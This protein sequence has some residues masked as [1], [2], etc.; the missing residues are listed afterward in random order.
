LH[1][2]GK[3]FAAAIFTCI[4]LH[5][6]PFGLLEATAHTSV[7]FRIVN[8]NM[9]ILS[10]SLNGQGPYE[11]AFDTGT[12][13]SLVDSQLVASL[14]LL[15]VDRIA[16]STLTGT[17]SVPRYFIKTL[18]LGDAKVQQV[19]VLAEDLRALHAVDRRIRG[20]LGLSALRQY[21]FQIDNTQKRLDLYTGEEEQPFPTRTYTQVEVA[22]DCILIPAVS[23]AARGGTLK[24]GL[25]SGVSQVVVWGESILGRRSSSNRGGESFRGEGFTQTAAT[26]K[27]RTNLSE[28]SAATVEIDSLDIGPVRLRNL[29]VVVLGTGMPAPAPGEDGLLPVSLFRLVFFDR[30]NSRVFLEPK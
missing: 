5:A 8:G 28:S 14:G 20:I 18:T 9:L 4:G 24:L 3:Y 25:D 10:V 29:P 21:S 22:Q 7:P 2:L 26:A 17:T 15:P 27:V 6:S 23:R 16:L 19:E 30:K 12:N 11:F 1:P 13:T